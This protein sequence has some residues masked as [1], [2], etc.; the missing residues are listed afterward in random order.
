MDDLA[1]YDK[2]IQDEINYIQYELK[3]T[4]KKKG[5][6]KEK[7]IRS[8]STKVKATQKILLT[9]EMQL[10]IAPNSQKLKYE[11]KYQEKVTK[12]TELNVELKNM[13]KEMEKDQFLTDIHAVNH[14]RKDEETNKKSVGDMNKQEIVNFGNKRLDKAD[15]ELD[16]ATKILMQGRDL[17]NDIQIVCFI[18]YCFLGIGKTEKTADGDKREG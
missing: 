5:A 10:S 4:K 3:R 9:Y 12:L 2:T 15:K 14:L 1:E 17:N 11:D 7:A 18:Y 13:K 8:L 6:D 16:D